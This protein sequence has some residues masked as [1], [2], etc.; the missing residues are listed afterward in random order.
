MNSSQANV[1]RPQ[2]RISVSSVPEARRLA[3]LTVSEHITIEQRGT[4]A[5]RVRHARWLSGLILRKWSTGAGEGRVRGSTDPPDPWNSELTSEI[6][7]GAYVG[8]VSK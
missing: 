5:G 3:P 2:S 1:Y 4:V 6:A 7:H 8:Q